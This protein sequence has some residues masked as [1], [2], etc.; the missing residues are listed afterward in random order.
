ML[1]VE[2]QREHLEWILAQCFIVFSHVYKHALLIGQLL[3]LLQLVVKAQRERD[4]VDLT[5]RVGGL[6]GLVLAL[7]RHLGV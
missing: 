3:V 4:L 1:R 5:L 2:R 7:A 6:N